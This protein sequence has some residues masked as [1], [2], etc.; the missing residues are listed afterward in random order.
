[1]LNNSPVDRRHRTSADRSRSALRSLF[2]P[3]SW[4][5]LLRILHYYNYTHTAQ[6]RRLTRGS[7][8]R[9][10]PNVSFANGERVVLGDRVQIGARCHLWAGDSTSSITIGSDSTFGPECFLT[11]SDYGT[12]PGVPIAE[13]PKTERDITIGRDVW[14]GARTVVTA[15]VTIGDGCVVGAG[16]VVVS[17]IPAGSVAVGVPARVVR[18]RDGQA[19][20][21]TG[22]P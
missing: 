2:D 11:A 13:Q 21:S 6:V 9:I 15:G 10:A 18:S 12:S 17:D 22:T 20:I 8:V 5:H 14:L 1:M 19:M 4:L 3:R 16:A 7:A